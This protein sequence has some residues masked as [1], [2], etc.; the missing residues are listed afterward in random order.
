MAEC[1]Y[2]FPSR[3]DGTGVLSDD[4]YRRLRE[5]HFETLTSYILRRMWGTA[6]HYLPTPAKG[7]L[8]VPDAYEPGSSHWPRL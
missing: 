8:A 5:A 6:S 1:V 7:G 2:L 3:P 4:R